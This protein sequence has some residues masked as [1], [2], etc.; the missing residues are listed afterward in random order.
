MEH[1]FKYFQNKDCKYFPCHKDADPE[2]FNC[3]FCFCPLYFLEDCGGNPKWRGNVKDC[4][5]C[6]APHGK[7]GYEHV[8]T[9]LKREF[10]AIRAQGQDEDNTK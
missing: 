4:T 10:D 9:R 1:S 5:D 6:T 2:H 3:L 8:L 7:D